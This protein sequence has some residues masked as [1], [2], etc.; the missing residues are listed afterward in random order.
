MLN[1]LSKTLFVCLMSV[2]AISAAEKIYIDDES[3]DY[4]Q[5]S[6]HIHIGNNVWLETDT[7]HRDKSGLYTFDTNLLRS[8]SIKNEFK[9]TWKCPYCYQY[10]P[11]GTKCQNSECPSKY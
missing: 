11:L 7:V 9:K 10:W 2:S 4:K 6:F 1:F 3:L 5:D 8:K